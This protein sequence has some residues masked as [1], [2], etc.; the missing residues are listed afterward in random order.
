MQIISTSAPIPILELKRKFT[1]DVHFDINYGESKFKGKALLMYL[2]NL[3]IGADLLVD[4]DGDMAELVSSYLSLPVMYLNDAL[5]GIIVNL[6]LIRNGLL[7]VVPLDADA[8][9]KDNSDLLD[10]WQDRLD[11]LPLYASRC[12]LGDKFEVNVGDFKSVDETTLGINWIHCINHP[13]M[14]M[15]Y[16]LNRPLRYSKYWFDEPT[17]AGKSLY[18]HFESPDNVLYISA[19]TIF[20]PEFQPE[21]EKLVKDHDVAFLE[22]MK[23]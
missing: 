2:G 12:L 13:A 17:F 7:G 14:A 11:M 15:Y 22:L 1:E 19:A 16:S 10:I 21:F 8:F 4:N 18:N 3:N 9:I 23:E 20:Q 6:L 5:I